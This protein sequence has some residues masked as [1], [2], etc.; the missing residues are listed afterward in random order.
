MGGHRA[1]DERHWLRGAI[2]RP[3]LLAI[4]DVFD[5]DEPLATAELDDYLDP[6][7]LEV[8]FDEGLNG[9]TT[10]R[11]DVQ[12]TTRNDYKFHYTDSRGVDLRWGNHPH[13][14]E[15]VNVRGL[16]HYH[17]PPNAS[18]DPGEVED[19]CITHSR[20]TLVARAVL[21]LWRVA[22]HADSLS[23]LNAGSN[24]P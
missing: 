20:E 19:S 22:Y 11:I 6:R 4:R 12:W 7:T 1:A 15:Y 10:A 16:A 21:K 14:D 2:D 24:P 23:P 18:S 13:N 5:T 17:P 9:A 3:A 8:T